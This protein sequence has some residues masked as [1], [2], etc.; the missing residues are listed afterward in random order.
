MA[1]APGY[2]HGER[3]GSAKAI[4]EAWQLGAVVAGSLGAHHRLRRPA[5]W[6]HM[7]GIAHHCGEAAAPLEWI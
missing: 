3:E 2:T 6:C 4:G 5:P 1:L 7:L